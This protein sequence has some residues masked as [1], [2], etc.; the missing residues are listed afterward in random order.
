MITDEKLIKVLNAIREKYNGDKEAIH[1]KMDDALL[2][3]IGNEEVNRLF[4]LD[5]KWSA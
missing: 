1:S 4:N 5:A 2:E 3:Y